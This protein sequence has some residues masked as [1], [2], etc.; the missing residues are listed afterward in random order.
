[1]MIRMPNSR[2]V[3]LPAATLVLL[4]LALL[5]LPGCSTM[6]RMLSMVGLSD[7]NAGPETPDGMVM[8]GVEAFNLGKYSAALKIFEDLRDRYPFSRYSLLADLKVADCKYYLDEYGEA[9]SLYEEFENN[10]PTNEAIPYVLFQIGMCHYKR[11]GTI[12]RDTSGAVSAIQAFS[13]QIRSYPSS[14][15]FSEATA[16]IKAAQDFLARHEMYVA[17]FYVRSSEYS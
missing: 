9:L 15:Y 2:P 13:R 6:D 12:D 8:E 7:E 11:I 1:M 4:G 5:A 14:P 10:H 16:R 3:L 17:V